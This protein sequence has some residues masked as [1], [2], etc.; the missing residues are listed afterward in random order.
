MARYTRTID[1]LPEIFRTTTNEKFLNATLDQI[2]Q[3]PQLRKVEGYIGRRVGLGVDGKDSYVLEQDQ[4][5]AAYQLEPTVTWK[6]KDTNQTHDFLTYPGIVDALQ[7][8]SALTDRHDRLFDSEYY[9]WDPFVDYDK[10]VN[11]SQYYWLPQG[12]DSVDV[13]ST[14][15]STS[16]AYT[17]TRNEFD[18]TLSGV[19]GPNPTITVVRGGNYKFN[20]QQTGTPF[21]IQAA[22]GSNGQ[23]P[24][25]PNQSSREVMGVTNNGDD[26]GIVE[27][28][29]PLDTEQNF[30]L[31]MDTV[32]TVD[33]VTSLR[34]DEIHNQLVRP[35]LDKHDGIDEVTDLRNRTIIFINRNP[36]NGDD[37]GWKRD[38]RFDEARF[39]ENGTSF[40]ESEE[41]T[42][43]T[44]R[45]S[46]YRIEYRY[47]GQDSSSDVFDA[48]GK[49]PYM[50]LNKVKEIPSLKKVHIQYGTEYNNKFMWKTSEGFF[51]LQPH[52]TAINDTL[53]YQDGTD[54]NRFGIIRVV[55]AVDQLTLNIEDIIGK[56]QY[57]SPTGVTFSNGMKVQFRGGTKPEQYQDK[58]YYVEGVGTAIKLLPVEEFLTPESYTISETQPFDVSGYDEQPWDSSLNAP[59][60]KDYITINRGSGDNNP[61]SRSNR[62]F[63]ISV[64][65]ASAEYNKTVA[66]LDQT[67]RA[68]RPILE[69][70]DGLRLFN[71]GTDGKRAVDIIDLRQRDA[72][73]N[74]AGKIGYNI[75][76]LSLFDGARIIFA[77]DED[78]RVRNKIYQVRMVDPIGLT[79]D[80]SQLSEKIIQLVEADDTNVLQDQTVFVKSG[81]TLQ[82]KSYRYDGTKWTAT[83]QKTKV[84]QAPLFDIF[85]KA[86]S[87]IGNTVKYPSTNFTGT[88]L[89]SYASGSGPLDSEL[90]MRLKYLN[91]NNVGD[92]VFENNLYKDTFVYTINN[93]ST[94]TDVATGFIRKYTDRTNFKLQT[95][96]EKAVGSTRQAQIFTFT[97]TNKCICDVRY[98]D[99]DNKV[100]VYADNVYI[101]PSDY[102]LTRTAKTSTIE[103]K[104]KAEIINIHII[105]DQKSKVAYYEMPSNLSD[106]SVNDSFETVTLGTIRNHF[107]GLAQSHPELKGVVL[108]ENNIRDL[109]NIV[110][111]G[112]QIVEQ[113]SPLQFTAIFAKDSNINFFD[114]VEYASNEYEKFKTRLIDTLT[115][116]DYQGT[117]DERLDQAFADLNKGRNPDMPFYWADT[118]P[119]GQ[120][121]EE[122]KITITPIDDNVF[123]L[124]KI[125]DFTKANY[126]GLL[127]Y[128]NDNILLKDIDYTISTDSPRLTVLKTLKQGDV[129]R[130]REYQSTAGSF[131]PPTPTKLGMF[132]V[133]K[134][135]VFTDDSYTTP[136]QILQGHDGSRII[137]FGDNRDEVLYEFES[138]IYNNIKV[139]K[140]R[141]I[142][143]RWYDIIPGKF[144]TTDYADSEITDLMS[145]SFL[146]W[147]AWNKLDYKEQ[148]YDSNNKKTWNYSRATDR[149]DGSLLKGGWRAN[150]YKFYDTDVPHLRPWEMFGFSEEPTWWQRQYGPAPYTGDNMVLWDDMANGVVAHPDGD[151][152]IEDFKR[153]RLQEVIPTGDEGDLEA[154]FDVLVKNYD[155][156]S[157]RKSWLVGDMGP[158]ETAWRRSSAYPFA[159]MKL[160]AQTKPAQFF[161]LMAD[162]DRYIYSSEL[163]QYVL[164]GRYRLTSQNIEIYGEGTIKHSYINW[165]VD[166][167]RRQGI[168]NKQEIVD[169]FRN[170]KINLVYRVGGFTDKQ[171]L[172]MFTEKTSPNSLNANLLLPDESYEILL[173]NNEPFDEVVYSSVI[174]QKVKGGYAVYGN[175][176]ETPYFKVY[177]SITNGNYKNVTVGDDTVRMSLDFTNKEVLIPYGYTFTSKGAMVD[178]LVSYGSWL[179]SKGFIFEDKHDDYLLNWGQMVNEFLYWNQ[180]GW[181]EGAIINLNPAANEIRIERIGAVAAPMLGRRADEFILDQNLQPIIKENL[182]WDR[183]GNELRISS[184]DESAISFL[185]IK[186]TSYEHA[187]V[188]SNT[189]IFNDLLY[190]PATGARQQRLKIVGTFSD[191]W[192][193]TI[194]APGFIMN[195]PNVEEW[196]SNREYSKGDIVR[197]KSNYYSALR[198]LNPAE[199]FD[200][201]DWAETEYE[202]VKTG[203]LPNIALKAQQS[204]KFYDL[205][206]ANL[207]SDADLLGFGLIGFRTRNYMQGLNLDDVSQTNVY[208]NFIG[209]KG[210]NRA[211]NLFKS[212]QLDKELTEYDIYENWA[213]RSGF[214]GANS[215]RSYV[216]VNL[217]G[218]RLTGNPATVKITNSSLVGTTVNQ[219]VR[220]DDI[221]KSSYKVIDENILPT[222]DYQD[223]ENSLPTAGFVNVE[224]VDIKSYELSSLDAVV[225]NLDEITEGTKIW[226]AKDNNYSWNVYRA[227][228]LRAEPILVF[229]NLDGTSSITFNGHHH[230]N[231]DDI[232]VIKFFS[233]QVDGAF[234]VKSVTAV[235]KIIVDLEFSSEITVLEDLGVAFVLQSSKVFQGSDI[236]DLPF[237]KNMQTGEK[238]WVDGTQWKVLQKFNPFSNVNNIW[239]KTL[240]T[241]V[242]NANFGQVVSQ[243][244]DGL[245]AMVG[246]PAWRDRGAV[247]VW[248]ALGNGDLSEGTRLSL[249]K[250]TSTVDNQLSEYGASVDCANSGW[251]II[252][253]PG[254]RS[255][256][257]LAVLVKQVSAGVIKELQVL[258]LPGANRFGESVI[259]TNDNKWAF[260]GSPGDEK[261]YAYQYKEYEQQKHDF[262]ADGTS[263]VYNVGDYIEVD[264]ETQI[265]MNID[266]IVQIPVTDYT[267]TGGN[268]TFVEAPKAGQRIEI[269][270][271]YVHQA[272]GDGSTV[273]YNISSLYKATSI[274]TFNVIL[275]EELLRPGYDYTFNPSTKVIT[276]TL[277]NKSGTPIAPPGGQLILVETIDHFK[278]VSTIHNPGEVGNGFGTSLA[279]TAEGRQ[280][281][282]GAT[283][284]VGEDSTDSIG[285]VYVYDRDV[286]RF[287][288]KN[289][290]TL[291]F[292]TTEAIQGTA[293][294]TVNN[295]DLYD[296]DYYL[297]K[298]NYTQSGQTFTIQ[299]AAV[300]LGD[301]VEIE[302]N[303]FRLAG[304]L[305]KPDVMQGAQFGYSVKVCPTNC[306]IYVGAPGDSAILDSAGSVTRFVNR[307]RLYGSITGSIANPVITPGTKLRIN[308]YYVTAT[309]T[310]VEDFVKDIKDAN[311]PNITASVVD[312]KIKINLVNVNAAPAA[313]KLYIYPADSSSLIEDLGLEL[314]PS[315]QTIQNPYPITNARF[316]HALDISNDAF[317]VVIGAPNGAT[318][319]E[320][321]L[322]KNLTKFD[323]GGT[324]IKDV[325]TQSGAVYTYDYLTSDNDT[326]DNPGKFAYGQ[327]I[328]DSQVHPL[329]GFGTS[330]DY[331][332]AKLL[333]GAPHQLV[334]IDDP[335]S[336]KIGR[337]VR[338]VNENFTPVWQVV[339]KETP[340]VNTKLINSMFIYNKVTD[341]VLTYL[342]YIDPVQGKILGAAQQNIDL[343]IPDD[344]AQYNNGTNNNF[345]MTW[346][347]E[348]VGTIWWD[349]ST[350]KF[351]N[352]NQSTADYRAKRIGN[353]F[354]G[355]SIDV[356]QWIS[357]DVPPGEYEGEGQ[358]FST[359]DYSLL[360]DVRQGGE[361]VTK[362]Y[363][364]V[365]N[366]TSVNRKQG[367]TLSPF[368]IKQYIETPKSSGIPYIAAVDKNTFALF[369]AQEYIQDTNS[370]LHI[371]FDKIETD[372]NVHVEYELIREK[373]PT[374]FLTDN[375]YRKF[376]DSFC[377]VDTAGNIVPDPTLSLTDRRGVEFRPR[378]TMF[379]DRFKA[380]ENYLTAVN[381]ILKQLPITEI[382]SYPLLNSQEEMPGKPSGTWDI[383]LEDIAE[384][385]YQ[386]LNI[387]P[388]GYRYLVKSDANNG[389]LW[390]I[391]TL[392]PNRTLLL[393]RVQNYKTTRYWNFVD[394]YEAG[395]NTLDKPTKEVNQY[396]DL[397][398][399]TTAIVGSI[400]KVRSNA[401]GKFEIYRK[402]TTG[403][404]RVGLEKGTI[405][406]SNSIFDYDIDRNGFDNEVFDAQYFDQEAVLELRQIIKSINEELFVG[407]LA[408][409][410]IA[411]ITLMFNY[412]LSE[413]QSTDWLVKT[414]LID[415]KHTLRELKPF[416][417]LKRDNQ[418]FVEQY[419]QEVK[420]YRTQVK[421]FNLVY[422]G[423]DNFKGD[424]TDFD[425]P[426]QFNTELNKYISPRHVLDQENI[427]GEGVYQLTDPIWLTGNYSQWRQNF[428]LSIRSV[429]VINPGSGYSEPPQVII[430]GECDIPAEMTA[431]V[432]SAGKL[433][434]VN[435]DYPG[436][437]YTST[438][439]ITLK[440]G[441]GTGAKVAAITAP[442]DVRSYTTTIKFDRYEY[443]TSIV[444]W[445]PET[446]YTENQLVRFNNKVYSIEWADGSTLTKATFDPLDYKL[447]DVTDLSGVDRTMGLY[448]PGNNYPGLDLSLLVYGT[449]YPGVNILGPNFSQN[450]GWDVGNWDVNPYDNIDF[451]ENGKPSYS[452]TIL[453]AKY[454]GGDYSG[455]SADAQYNVD[456]ETKVFSLTTSSPNSEHGDIDF[457]F[458]DPWLWS[459]ESDFYRPTGGVDVQKPSLVLQRG[460]TY[461]FENHTY[462][463]N[464][465]L[466]SKALSEAEYVAGNTELYILSQDDGVIN[467]G[468]K[469][470]SPTDLTPAVITWTVPLDYP[471]DSVVIQHSQYGMADTVKISGEI[472]NPVTGRPTDIDVNG[473]AFVDSYNSHAPQEL[474]PGAMF[475]TLNIQVNTRPGSDYTN[476]GWAGQSQTKFFT[477]DGTNRTLSFDGL[478]DVPSAVIAYEVSTGKQLVF[479]YGDTP[480]DTVDYTVNWNDKT[481]TL[482][483]GRFSTGDIIG[484]TAHGIG[485]GNQL[486]V[487]DY[488]AEDYIT[489]E[490]HAEFILPIEHEQIKNLEVL[491]NGEKIVNW[492]LETYETWHTKLRVGS[493]DVNGDGA[494]DVDQVV[495]VN[496]AVGGGVVDPEY[497]N[498]AV[499]NVIGD[500]SDFFKRE[501]TTNGV[502]IMGAGTVGGQT[503]VPDAWLEKV[504]RMFELFTDSSG[505]G[506]NEEYQRNLIKTLSGDIGTYHAGKPTIQ[507]VARGAGSDYNPNFL[508]DAGVIAWNLTD[509]FD[510]TVQNDMVWYLNSTGSGYGDGDIDA[511]E[512]IE[513]VFH[514]LHMHGL[515]A[516]DIKLYPFLA[517]DWDT[518]ELYAAM[519][520]AYDAGKWDPSGYEPSPGAF[521]TNSDAFEV[522]AKEYLYLLNFC[523][524]EYTDLWEGG[525]LAPEWSDDMRTKAGILANNPL[526]YA[527]HNT[528][529][530]PVISKPSLAT[531]RSIFQDGNTPAQD[532]PALAG[533]SGYV[534][535]A[536]GGKRALRATDYIHFAVLGHDADYEPSLGTLLLEYNPAVHCDVS[537][538]KVDAY[539]VTD[540]SEYVYPIYQD[541]HGHGINPEFAQV[542]LNGHRL[543][544]PEG[545][546]WTGDGVTTDFTLDLQTTVGQGLIADNDLSVYVDEYELTLYADYVLSPYDGSSDRIVTLQN[547]PADG[548]KVKIFVNTGAEYAIHRHSH[549]GGGVGNS[550]H[551]RS[552]GLTLRAGD[553]IAVTSWG[554][555]DELD[556][557]TRVYQGP[558]RSGFTTRT[559]FDSVGFDTEAGFDRQVGVTIDQ[560]VYFLGR[561]ITA[562]ERVIVSVNGERKF[563][564]TDW[565]LLDGDNRYI[566][567]YS[568]DVQSSDLVE[569]SLRTENLVPNAMT[570]QL[571]KDMNDTAGIWRCGVSSIARLTQQVEA[572]DTVIY[573]DDVTKLGEPK[574]DEGLFGFVMI[575]AER[576]SY[577][578]RDLTTNSISG[579]RRGVHGTAITTHPLG[580]D[581]VSMASAEYVNWSYSQSLYVNNGKPLTQ[582]ETIPAKFLRRAN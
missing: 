293:R 53:Y 525:S 561:T 529:I 552:S 318:N 269:V 517:A 327:Q 513:H 464:L 325:Q 489:T 31:N 465:W 188:F 111:Y 249:G 309:G 108:G 54:T 18:Y 419:I 384:L 341:K 351:I 518:S 526:G 61:W 112:K 210:S 248:G 359:E 481:I 433:I 553:H 422:K 487:K 377:G 176:K 241:P 247:H 115:K 354:P 10:H 567:F 454:Q 283:T 397:G 545:L 348:R 573:L 107:V 408:H 43:K 474:V 130:I 506:I 521:K 216:E 279:T 339:E 114:S 570:F 367:K 242:T 142:P 156:L 549:N 360:S 404:T 84:N 413:Q 569:V 72:L 437:G 575:G 155:L 218:D 159:V 93:V 92:I 265:S 523:M 245:T 174:V 475:D 103:L 132:N 78:P 48:S 9:S 30:F 20:V 346:G 565:K 538:P 509:L 285:K 244:P 175:S 428:A 17:V 493:R 496:S 141:K 300:D 169:L 373:D 536:I 380:L 504:A 21:W 294:V 455:T 323:A 260:V 453:D 580:T 347:A 66:N 82:G 128:L 571:F 304:I 32:G 270:R 7:V 303:N 402:D 193:G 34:F 405:K 240:K 483:D 431:R 219:I 542:M 46:I 486:L 336:D 449:E 251:H 258:T 530:K 560:S 255:N 307:S 511:Q 220:L 106:N 162:R 548:K 202:S 466:R 69:F 532:N 311:L 275:D 168:V 26:N 138:R 190:D 104:T 170:T 70:N 372:N 254:H 42:S 301:F 71:F 118:I 319:L 171:Y 522:A 105:S 562:P 434:A 315:M 13:S 227:T 572:D 416:T 252:G 312:S 393:T 191:N 305:Y 192:D 396:A 238:I 296:S 35:F 233:Q 317:S 199:L 110:G 24:G 98:I 256:E 558:T 51:E 544:P 161:S 80:P 371:E 551:I 151:Y 352:Y 149:L 473:G 277:T 459:W 447:V 457:N 109:G 77:V 67:A 99:G 221:Y 527:F 292:T 338:F 423:D 16:D 451:D 286:E 382:R 531:I 65:K 276:F 476:E 229:D 239:S 401:Q 257:G 96:W 173:Y 250:T 85:D 540:A 394:W 379:V 1:L 274:E 79:E 6:K 180:Q 322:D 39:D 458:D 411:L 400:V 463:H 87:S 41:I 2:V 135:E 295:A 49:N 494:P 482:T 11:F 195:Q 204:E 342:D 358:V 503:A 578:K 510:N 407:D 524:F 520:E 438:P 189:S 370:V 581:V 446:A 178:F 333:I 88:K 424:P 179:Q 440:G 117:A 102:T 94:T 139:P 547:A 183:L 507:R 479:E 212:A 386:K 383:M 291:A 297:L 546:E 134:P 369:N 289:N 512:V 501:V 280:L 559:T 157:T 122:S 236:A 321:T 68:K 261:V 12:P 385:S 272:T 406:I 25:Q 268:I 201:A 418:D 582:Q 113:S 76:G 208:K 388:I 368:T 568:V 203:M 100:V 23:M 334:D 243:T 45:Y 539:Y 364:W 535:D 217:N 308:N 488:I 534:A 145:E 566:E 196:K 432:S 140:D 146:S 335:T 490:G 355:S 541:I 306:S 403:W 426:A 399:L 563:Y 215:N 273:D 129:I 147:V 74:V 266:N 181:Q 429:A 492:T 222:V 223:V 302:T 197:Y 86:G 59:T 55:D 345:G 119:C 313:N 4:E 125:Y 555:T 121:Y 131:V 224:D 200:F 500:G 410:R 477:F 420:P 177:E 62:W 120:V 206:E 267:M 344:P 56:K 38:S 389:N 137:T 425:L 362:Y 166:F 448:Q 395:Y 235:D 22:P 390:T 467:N 207:E 421:E 126:Q 194:N 412:V 290:T 392:Q 471:G 211:M 271:K 152:I 528:Y 230:L 516:D 430:T 387:D 452:E 144:R 75:D 462:G 182:A 124:L 343:T 81:I 441:N 314:F 58:S 515:P 436:Q 340:T 164:D 47:E 29:V 225:E 185:K 259:F 330:V 398:T 498:G 461:K 357:S 324:K 226:V 213:V 232:V 574:I 198:R 262:L 167:A 27:F 246:A 148:D 187:L 143:L 101:N 253:A 205:S 44:D 557:I 439:V 378:Q 460:S 60:I 470:S 264:D 127:V 64:I 356:Y 480:V 287:Q 502:R 328:N 14:E 337:I 443:S 499:T 456:L 556:G 533:A 414:S 214:Y 281:F 299:D 165:C 519:V 184:L 57:T 263:L 83:Q 3:R 576:I 435:V 123:D 485:G 116:N 36:G 326:Y 231:K 73:S 50:V 228:V 350:A 150:L 329:S 91:I 52:I 495:N 579:L 366:L 505:A 363:F 478:I 550:L 445:E 554:F 469:R 90:G 5:R 514:T 331:G 158:V 63:H 163:D 237:I 409:H 472:I 543:R 417:I 375:L 19:E 365:K 284:G 40:A 320:V 15:I 172:K 153:P 136:Q 186:F 316:G 374:Q 577:R 37:S 442:G 160:L 381:R 332:N 468:A 97:N 450:T 484:I 95:G 491:V 298:G 234:K 209:A 154:S 444:D 361:L 33:L 89:F 133:F 376:L 282:I 8:N 537:Y 427:T 353:L 564:G 497:N 28:N 391:Y 415:V 508:T 349:V 310:T 288:V 278:Y